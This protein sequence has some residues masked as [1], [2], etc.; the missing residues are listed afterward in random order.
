MGLGECRSQFGV[1][2]D[3]MDDFFP[4]EEQNKQLDEQQ[5]CQHC[6][7]ALDAESRVCP[8]CRLAQYRIKKTWLQWVQRGLT[9]PFLLDHR[10]GLL[11]VLISSLAVLSSFGAL[12]FANIRAT[13]AET[14]MSAA[15]AAER[16][17]KR[18][19]KEL[20]DVLETQK[21]Q[22]ESLNSRS[23]KLNQ[24]LRQR[25]AIEELNLKAVV[26]YSRDAFEKLKSLSQDPNESPEVRAQ[27]KEKL[28]SIRSFYPAKSA[29]F[30]PSWEQKPPRWDS[31]CAA[32]KFLRDSDWQIRM[33]A[34]R[35][36]F[37]FAE[38]YKVAIQ[39]LSNESD[40]RV[41]DVVGFHLGSNFGWKGAPSS[42]ELDAKSY[43]GLQGTGPF[44]TAACSM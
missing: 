43:Q 30:G 34:V 9:V 27:A 25:E 16:E 5:K 3:Q 1:R 28:V 42:I 31:A 38:G 33:A 44:K 17:V 22:V 24:D 40:L 41:V 15:R 13:S 11:T 20:G 39:I 35:A 21:R 6:R 19:E 12:Y 4:D 18:I 26:N 14:A 32:L 37:G 10:V 8:H 36:L 2:W 7:K 29:R 23:S